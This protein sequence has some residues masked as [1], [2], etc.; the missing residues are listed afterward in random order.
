MRKT[1]PGLSRR[2]LVQ[3]AALA[4]LPGSRSLAQTP[5]ATPS[6]DAMGQL[7]ALAA[8]AQE[9][10]SL[11]SVLL[12][13]HDQEGE[14]FA[15]ARGESETGMPA[16]L[17]MHFRIGAVSIT[18]LG[19]L[20]LNLADEGVIDIDEPIARWLPDLPHA[21]VATP[22][23]LAQMTAGYPDYV[24]TD[25]FIT[26][27]Y[28]DPFRTFTAEERIQYSLDSP[29]LFQPGEN[30]AYSHT[31]IV[32]LGRVIE[33]AAGKPLADLMMERV[34]IPL[35][36][37]DTHTNDLPHM[38]PP[39]LHSYSSERRVPLGIAPEVPFYEDATT[40]NPSWTLAPGSVQYSTLHDIASAFR[41][42]GQGAILSGSALA[43]LTSDSLIGFGTPL[44]G[45]MNCRSLDSTYT[46]GIGL[47][48]SN[49][50]YTQNPMF[51]GCGATVATLPE[52]GYTI[53]AA[54]TFQEDAFD[55]QG[56]Y[57]HGNSSQTIVSR[58]SQ[59]LVPDQPVGRG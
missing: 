16:M 20:L 49:G 12:T 43:E 17:D 55:D 6:A 45:C 19:V 59:L 58:V 39:V 31:G 2:S 8:S 25:A 35:G 24:H 9:E 48:I 36:L 40:W 3:G 7:S 22:R 42:V 18:Y 52:A 57:I 53:A 15:L 44:D 54:V 26:A 56:N 50:W 1:L 10:F 14:V 11:R 23:M 30:W 4:S 21:D 37:R 51:A 29:R 28:R 27:F 38:A 41:Q 32:I 33:L 47:V 34:L 13:V 46:Y 5:A